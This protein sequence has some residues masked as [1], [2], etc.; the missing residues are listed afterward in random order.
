MQKTVSRVESVQ[1]ILV[2][3]TDNGGLSMEQRKSLEMICQG[4]VKYMAVSEGNI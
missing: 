2:L 1:G 3:G 4:V